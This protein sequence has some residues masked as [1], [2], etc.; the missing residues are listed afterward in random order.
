MVEFLLSLPKQD[1]E[2]VMILVG[3]YPT[4][5]DLS[6]QEKEELMMLLGMSAMEWEKERE[7]LAKPERACLRLIVSPAGESG[8]A[9]PKASVFGRLVAAVR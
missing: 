9:R 3:M 1:K 4:E 6:K 5:W 7:R 8:Q 2:E